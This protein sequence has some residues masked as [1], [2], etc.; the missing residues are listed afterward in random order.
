MRREGK[1]E[2]K[3]RRGVERNDRDGDAVSPAR[4]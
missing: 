1:E 2:E 3:R 4:I